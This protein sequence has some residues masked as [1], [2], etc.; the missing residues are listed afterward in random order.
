MGTQSSIASEEL[1]RALR[2]E[3]LRLAKV[4]DELATNE[5]LGVLYW[6]PLPPS[7]TSHRHCAVVLRTAAERLDEMRLAMRL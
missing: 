5:A 7:V 1:R 3:L 4:E 6:Q 2:T